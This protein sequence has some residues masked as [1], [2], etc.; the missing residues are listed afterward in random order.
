[1]MEMKKTMGYKILIIELIICLVLVTYGWLTTPGVSLLSIVGAYFIVLLYS[2]FLCIALP[3]IILR[4]SQI[5][6]FSCFAGAIAGLIFV[7]EIIYEYIFLPK[8]NTIPGLIEFG[9]VLGVLFLLAI[10]YSYC[11]HSFKQTILSVIISAMI[12]SVLWLITVLLIF[13]LFRGTHRQEIVL[14]AE[15]SYQ[16][17]ANSGMKSFDVFI[18]EDFYGATFFHLLLVPLLA[19][20]LSLF[21]WIIGRISSLIRAVLK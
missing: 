13:Y 16:D 6:S 4:Y 7:G 3:R 10:A 8:D 17:F 5:L 2:V 1:M 18:M 20:I 21:G 11:F 9:G 19:T 14:Q 15:G 12:A